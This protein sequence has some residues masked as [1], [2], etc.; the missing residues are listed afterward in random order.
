MASVS[1]SAGAGS[2]G[3]FP[4]RTAPAASSGWGRGCSQLRSCQTTQTGPRRSSPPGSC[5]VFAAPYGN[6]A[7]RPRTDRTRPC[8]CRRQCP[9][10]RLE[11]QP[12]MT[13]VPGALRG[14]DAPAAAAVRPR[15]AARRFSRRVGSSGDCGLR[16][17]IPR[18]PAEKKQAG[19]P[20]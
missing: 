5:S 15:P 7:I 9:L 12:R 14:G 3:S 10:R 8:L 18:G 13:G 20:A 11:A 16:G 1:G 2:N 4:L 6:V 19:Q 17:G